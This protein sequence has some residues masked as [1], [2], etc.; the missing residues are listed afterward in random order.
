MRR[1]I[2][3][4][5]WMLRNR[6]KSKGSCDV[7]TTPLISTIYFFLRSAVSTYDGNSGRVPKTYNCFS[8]LLLRLLQ[9]LILKKW[10]KDTQTGCI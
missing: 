5:E 1:K 7:I 2:N 9:L 3:K 4:R 6:T 10:G 8:S